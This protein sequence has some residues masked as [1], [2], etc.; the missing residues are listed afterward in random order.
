MQR[1][2]FPGLYQIALPWTNV[3]LLA[4]GRDAVLID[5]GT[6]RDRRRLLAALAEALPADYRLHA[7]LLTHGH[8]DH[9]GNAAFLA[10]RFGARL[11]AHR[12]EVPFLAARHTYIPRGLRALGPRGLIFALG[13][14][15]FPVK[16]R[17]VDVTLEEGDRVETPLG[18]LTVIHT[19]GHTPGH[20]AY[21]HEREG[22][23]FSGDALLNVIPFIMRTG[24]S[25]PPP[26]FS[27]DMPGVRRSARRIAEIGPRALLAGHGWPH[28]Q[29]T[30]AA[31]RA[32]VKTLPV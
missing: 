10:E 11:H 29:D 21:F 6:C 15:A 30:A 9:A 32:F 23:L 14:A 18:P 19:P 1:P 8:C 2:V 22:W 4:K 24:L 25:L 27:A 26:L 12:E 28:Q 31:L 5:C 17:A 20:T 13:E 7:V 16:R 3:W